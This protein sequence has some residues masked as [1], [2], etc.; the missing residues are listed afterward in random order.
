MKTSPWW[1]WASL[2]VLQGTVAACGGGSGGGRAVVNTDA[3]LDGP[4]SGAV[5]GGQDLTLQPEEAGQVDG[6]QRN[7]V[8][9]IDD[10]FAPSLPV[11]AGKLLA[12][13]TIECDP[14]PGSTDAGIADAGDA[15]V[16][17]LVAGENADLAQAKGSLL[18]ALAQ[19][20]RTC[21]LREG[22][23]AYDQPLLASVNQYRDRWNAAL[24]ASADLAQAFSS[25]ER[26][27]ISAAL[28]A[29]PQDAR[30]HGSFTAGLVAYDNPE[31]ELVLVQYPTRS[32]DE[33]AASVPC[34]AQS[35]IDRAAA[36]LSDPEI[37]AAYIARPEA[38]LDHALNAVAI[39]YAV[40]I[41]NVSLGPLA[42]RAVEDAMVANGCARVDL[43]PYQGLLTDLDAARNLAQPGVPVLMIESAGNDGV[44][45]DS[46]ADQSECYLD[47]PDHMLIGAYGV[48]GLPT[49]FTNFG[50][51]VALQA[52]GESVLVT[53]PGGWL[54]PEDGTSFS[55]PLVSWLASREAPQPFAPASTRAWLL[56]Q[57]DPS[58]RIPLSRFPDHTVYAPSSAVT[59]AAQPLTLGKPTL[60]GR[61][62][63]RVSAVQLHR[64]LW[65][66]E[67]VAGLTD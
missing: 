53:L 34:I 22:L 24:R 9:V 42:T 58:N 12:G 52:P 60:R 36:L 6:P 44:Q 31:V 39:R 56:A 23:D 27:Q 21:R 48:D 64:L 41:A 59:T 3:A 26:T 4:A 7:V 38:D 45:I 55:A 54:L 13:L 57:G 67:R 33:V 49:S 65:I 14:S 18:A 46:G 5:D 29:L 19:P 28:A 2:L 30:V 37:R 63:D 35:T 47:A 51:C 10:G 1:L 8:M 61:L 40:G 11:F 50:R 66:V 15:S 17:P 25:A 62:P 32:R 20:D 16:D 43:Q